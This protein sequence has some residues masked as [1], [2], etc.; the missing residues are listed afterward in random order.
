[1]TFINEHSAVKQFIKHERA[2]TS[3]VEKE[4]GD[5]ID[6]RNEAAHKQVENVLSS[7]EIGATGRFLI[8]LGDALADMVDERVLRQRMDLNQY[9]I[10][11]GITE[12][13]HD[14]YVVIGTPDAEVR[15]AVGDEV[16]VFGT[17]TCSRA[18]LESL[19]IGDRDEPEMT[20]NGVTEVGLRLSRPVPTPAEL[21]KIK[22]PAIQSEEI[23]LELEEMI[24][25]MADAAETDL[26][27]IVEAEPIEESG[28]ID[29]VVDA[30]EA[31]PMA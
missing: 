11:L 21:R 8:A 24:P 22:L 3:T 29:E 1:V 10:V 13:H 16:I 2:D 18:I 9:A 28:E 23:Q 14:G 5:F 26:P 15:L 12:I 20:G 27:E 19:R 30:E 17:G 7:E 25:A 4:L 6:Y 31:P